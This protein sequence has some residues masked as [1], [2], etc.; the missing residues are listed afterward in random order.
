MAKTAKKKQATDAEMIEAGLLDRDPYA[1]MTKA[2]AAA[3]DQET[4]RRS[5]EWRSD[6]VAEFQKFLRFYK[7]EITDAA[8]WKLLSDQVGPLG[9]NMLVIESEGPNAGQVTRVPHAAAVRAAVLDT[10]A[11]NYARLAKP[12][13]SKAK[14][15]AA[16][17]QR[18]LDVIPAAVAEE[19][20]NARRTNTP[21]LMKNVNATIARMAGCK[22]SVVEK[23]LRRI[24]H[25]NARPYGR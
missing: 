13:I 21:V 11:A 18:I 19:Q 24:R 4:A 22:V 14:K 17:R 3:F 20:E 7:V 16:L 25:S 12:I 6:Q 2:Q 23:T 10:A 9:R 5:A 1:G 8:A 15:S